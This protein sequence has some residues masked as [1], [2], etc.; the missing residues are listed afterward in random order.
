M[1]SDP[2]RLTVPVSDP[3]AQVRTETRYL[4]REEFRVRLITGRLH[5]DEYPVPAFYPEAIQ[6]VLREDQA[7][8]QV[9]DPEDREHPVGVQ[10][11]IPEEDLEVP[12]DRM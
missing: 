7:V 12:V 1:Y 10:V 5:R 2:E 11:V 9:E 8:I 4:D 3:E 6:V